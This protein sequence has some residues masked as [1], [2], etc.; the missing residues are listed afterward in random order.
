MFGYIK[1]FKPEMR[2]SEFE[3]YKS[4]YCSLC[5][6]LGKNYGIIS[7]LMLS[8][9]C[10]FLVILDLALKNEHISFT[11]GHCTFNP[12]KKY[13]YCDYNNDSFK[14]VGAACVV[15]SYYKIIDEIR[16]SKFLKRV[17]ALVIK[18]FFRLSYKKAKAE[19]NNIDIIVKNMMNA[20]IEVEKDK[21]ANIDISAQPTAE[22]LSELLS[23]LSTDYKTQRILRDF[24]YFIGRWIYLIDAC[25]DLKKDVKNK[26]F[27]PFTKNYKSG[28]NGN[29]LNMY[30]NQI[31]NQTLYRA[32]IAYN[33][34]P[35]YN[36][37]SILSNIMSL[38]LPNIQKQVL[39][40][41]KE[42]E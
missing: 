18:P 31:L 15:L 3:L 19:F 13:N 32:N 8:Y 2:I 27:N 7:R 10:T 38:G 14:F 11:K 23:L 34:L 35:I 40:D 6:S 21:N 33:L 42:R 25:D 30:L 39:F 41:R 22:M 37:K 26:A 12:L 20:Q 5:K 28:I 17:L 4:V 1:P 36:F 24:G 9:D 29:D 16:D